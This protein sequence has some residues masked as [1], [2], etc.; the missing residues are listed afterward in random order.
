VREKN[1]STERRRRGKSN[2][3]DDIS[4]Q[5]LF[6]G[7]VAVTLL[8]TSLS[9]TAA[10]DL[11]TVPFERYTLKNGLQVILVE[12]RRLPL[13]AVNLWYRVGAANESPGLT[14]FAHL[15]EH[16]MFTGTKHVP[17]GLAE[18][19]LEAA[20]GTE[21]NATTSFDRTNYFDTVP[22]HQLELALWAHADRMGYLLDA[23]DQTALANQQD[24]V[25][26][27]L[28]QNYENRPYGI[29][30]L[31][32]YRMLFPQGHPYRGAVIGTHADVQ[33]AKLDDLK[34]FFKLYYAP[35]NASLVIAGDIDKAAVKKLIEKYFGSFRRGPAVPRVSVVT[36]PITAE[37]RAVITD[38]VELARV[39]F[40]WLTPPAYAPGDAELDFAAHILGGGK[41]S[42]LYRKLVYE[43]EIA[44]D[45]GAWQSSQM[46][47]SVFTIEVTARP[48]RTARELEAAVAAELERFRKEGPGD[49][50]ME[51]ARNTI[52]TGFV[53]GLERL[54]GVADALNRY[55][56]YTGDPG[57]LPRDIERYRAVTATSVRSVVMKHL[58]PGARAVA[59]AVPG[60]KDL[61]PQVP[62]P[63]PRKYP[64][65]AGAEALNADE[66]WR[67]EVPRPGA[68]RALK[69]PAPKSFKLAN[70]L[71]VIYHERRDLPL[72]AAKLVVRTGGESNPP[73]RPGLASFTAEMLTEGTATRSALQIADEAAQ[74]G[75][76][77][78]AGA[79]SNASVVQSAALKHNFPAVL[80]LL[81][82]VVRNPA[83]P[84]AEIE[85]QRKSR[86][87]ALTQQREDPASLAAEVMLEVLYGPQHPYGHTSLGTGRSI[88]ATRRADLV[89]FWRRHYGP[90]NAALIVAGDI[91]EAELRPLAQKMFGDWRQ[92]ARTGAGLPRPHAAPA[93]IVLVDQPGAPSTALSVGHAGPARDTP[94]YAALQVMNAALGGLFTSRINMNLRE[95]KGYTYGA[96]SS[97]S[98]L[99]GGGPFTVR[100]T[101]RG[102]VTGAALEEIFKEVG[103]VAK[104]PPAG[105]ELERARNSQLLSLPSEFETNGATTAAFGQIYVHDLGDDYFERLPRQLKAVDALQAAAVARKYL[106]PA[107]LKIVAVGDRAKIEA[108]LRKLDLGR[109]EV[110]SARSQAQQ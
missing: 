77:V 108:P 21:S 86:E 27:E 47:A 7:V 68:A 28:R 70:G 9:A 16:M 93:R 106:A 5:S 90:S 71:A 109:I 83:F 11:P 34:R 1:E 59:H 73:R 92:G 53:Q 103:R 15:F 105:E 63:E 107:R 99:R 39:S 30:D 61:G 33:A 44:Q 50:E 36:P 6:R 96:G 31:A 20:G 37:R 38:R 74:L 25:R 56:F 49:A 94:D 79:L 98:F 78:V 66:P 97:F 45:V 95:E 72:V 24:V 19:L 87:A 29:V 10:T 60:K 26:N 75:T 88:K 81:A 41:S 52:E 100:T 76:T 64:P 17:R 84:A 46:L 55:A 22:S 65:G 51:R 91:G 104:E 89:D 8:A 42:R 14:G 2:Q 12:D 35:N 23:L 3:G 58:S 57:F 62:T 18:R 54:S 43:L 110:R 82:D 69:L 85:R 4:Y 102:E 40:A 32:L 101:V 67:R 13:V 80:G 48:G